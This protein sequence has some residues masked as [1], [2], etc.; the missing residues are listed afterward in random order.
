MNVE[1]TTSEA[2]ALIGFY[3]SMFALCMHAIYVGLKKPMRS[4]DDPERNRD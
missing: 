1:L 2:L 3:A 4:Y